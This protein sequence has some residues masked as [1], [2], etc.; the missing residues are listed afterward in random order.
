MYSNAKIRSIRSAVR[1]KWGGSRELCLLR[2][3]SV[4]A[5]RLYTLLYN[6]AGH[7]IGGRASRPTASGKDTLPGLRFSR[8]VVVRDTRFPA[9]PGSSMPAQTVSLCCLKNKGEFFCPFTLLH[10]LCIRLA[11]PAAADADLHGACSAPPGTCL[12]MSIALMTDEQGKI[13][14]LSRH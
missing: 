5:G 11:A 10:Y 4:D 7:I 13:R 12:P 1:G 2:Q 6:I 8:C 3:Y 14:T 9:L